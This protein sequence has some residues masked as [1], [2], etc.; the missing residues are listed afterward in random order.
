M[1]KIRWFIREEFTK[2]EPFGTRIR[3]LQVFDD[4]IL[5]WVDVPIIEENPR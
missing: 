1:L 2:D 3:M 4:N 5:E